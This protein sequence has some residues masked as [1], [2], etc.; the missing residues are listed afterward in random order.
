MW[1]YLCEG[2][3]NWNLYYFIEEEKN[4]MVDYYCSVCSFKN[5]DHNSLHFGG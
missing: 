2:K 3:Q 1:V 4:E 5:F